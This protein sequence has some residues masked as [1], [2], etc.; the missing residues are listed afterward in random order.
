VVADARRVRARAARAEVLG[1]LVTVVGTGSAR[2]GVVDAAEDRVD[3]LARARVA[4]V[5][6]RAPVSDEAATQRRN[7]L[8]GGPARLV[9]LRAEER[10]AHAGPSLASCHGTG[11]AV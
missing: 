4:V 8:V 9:G 5:G 6:T 10:L 1:A 2:E 3:A 11:G 7:W